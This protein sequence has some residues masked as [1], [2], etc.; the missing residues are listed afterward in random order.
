NS[1][2]PAS[3]GASKLAPFREPAAPNRGALDAAPIDNRNAE[4]RAVEP[5]QLTPPH[6][7]EGKPLPK[8]GGVTHGREINGLPSIWT[9]FGS[10][11]AVIAIFCGAMWMLK[12]GIPNTA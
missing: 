12:R 6:V 2:V 5:H 7:G 4:P 10:L 1:S 11:L 3:G 9:T 8:P